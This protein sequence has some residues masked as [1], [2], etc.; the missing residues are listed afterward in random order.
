[1]RE[2]AERSRPRRGPVARAA[3]LLAAAGLPLLFAAPSQAGVPRACI[4]PWAD[5]IECPRETRKVM[6][7]VLPSA[8]VRELRAQRPALERF[9]ESHD[10]R[11]NQLLEEI[12]GTIRGEPREQPLR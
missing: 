12:L 4:H 8:R 11:R 1:V 2:S 9:G 10:L 3:L 5:A 7:K 6:L